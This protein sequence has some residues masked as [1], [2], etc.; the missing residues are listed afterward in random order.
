MD[1]DPSGAFITSMMELKLDQ[2]T[3]FEWQKTSQGTKS[4]PHYREILEFLNLRAQACSTQEIK[5]VRN[6][7]R[8]PPSQENHPD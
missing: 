5:H 2:T 7:S 4:V 3:M 8:K 6:D 1:Q